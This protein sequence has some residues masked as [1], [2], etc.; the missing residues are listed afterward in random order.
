[1]AGLSLGECMNLSATA[2]LARS[3]AV[4]SLSCLL[5]AGCSGTNVVP[6][7]PLPSIAKAGDTLAPIELDRIV[8]NLERGQQIGTYRGN[9]GTTCAGSTLSP[10]P[11]NWWMGRA[12]I[13]DEE[14][15]I[16]FAKELR[17]AGYNVVG[18]P[19]ELFASMSAGAQQAEYLIGGR[20]DHVL[21]EVCDE[22][23]YW[24]HRKRGTQSGKVSMDVT[25][26]VFS[27]LERKVVLETRS[28]GSATLETGVP[29][30][31]VELLIRGVAAAAANLAADQNFHAV[32][33]TMSPVHKKAATVDVFAPK[34]SILIP[35]V[36]AFEGGVAANMSHIQ[37]AVVTVRSGT[38]QGSGFFVTPDLILTNEHVVGK[39]ARHKILLIDGREVYATTLRREAGRDVALLQVEQGAFPTLPLRL[40]LPNLAEEVY[41][42]GSPLDESLA[43]TVTRG[44][45]SQLQRDPQG[46]ELIQADVSIHPG[47]SGGPLL[48]G[49][50]NVIGLS[51][52]VLTNGTDH[53]IGI[54]FFIPIADALRFLAMQRE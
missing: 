24:A 48:D 44:I 45:V 22:Y 47:S 11:I 8:F 42:I 16:A 32:L 1:M 20:V 14:L 23:D 43:G 4:L 28:S 37:A 10:E 15:D 29:D 12:V 38:G 13:K 35:R 3:S 33:L 53:S 27:T 31:E 5:L 18:D 6:V 2:R 41:A 51:Q 46:L 50:G 30:G 9:M 25:W 26:Q 36:S 7:T 19:N 52:S 17:R 49:Q 39:G 21:M 54:N 40:S 34:P